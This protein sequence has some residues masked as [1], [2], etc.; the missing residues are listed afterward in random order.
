[1]MNPTTPQRVNE[2]RFEL[3]WLRVIAVLLLVPFH[4]ALIFSHHSWDIVYVKNQVSSLILVKSA[5]ML[6]QFHMPL[7]FFISGASSGFS[8]S[9]RTA[10]EYLN[11]RIKRLLIPLVFGL[12]VLV[13][14][15]LYIQFLWR[16]EYQNMYSSFFKYYPQFFQLSGD[17]SGYTGQFT[18]AHLWFISYLF[19]FSVLLLP[20]FS[21]LKQKSETPV[22]IKLKSLFEGNGIIIIP[23]ILL[24]LAQ[25]APC[26][27][28]VG[29]RNPLYYLLIFF[30]GYFLLGDNRFQ[31]VLKRKS[32]FSLVIAFLLTPILVLWLQ[33]FVLDRQ[34]SSTNYI[35]I[36]YGLI[37]SF[38][39]WCWLIGLTGVG[40]KYLNR[41]SKVLKYLNE[42]VYP[43]YILHLL[44]NTIIGYFFVKMDLSV[45]EKFFYIVIITTFTTFVVYDIFVRRRT[46]SRYVM[47]LKPINKHPN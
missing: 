31:T 6:H 16:P 17:F 9:F 2:R 36:C 37:S 15:M 11:E 18:P 47:G 46:L 1:M 24:L 42:S 25:A 40:T 21:S 44:I 38:V 19:V 13:P 45:Y 27:P 32:L 39:T 43:F 23:T 26:I 30:L 4:S 5:Y 10:T 41:K 12:V 14:P 8:L 28:C 22:I 34:L 3:D 35:S 7:L 20:I 29:G 33:P